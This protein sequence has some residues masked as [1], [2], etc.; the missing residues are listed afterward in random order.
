MKLYPDFKSAVNAMT[1][2]KNTFEP[3]KANADIYKNLYERVYLKM[4]RQLLPLYREIQAITGYP[5]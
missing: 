2:V 5:K 1:G 4:Y 3:V